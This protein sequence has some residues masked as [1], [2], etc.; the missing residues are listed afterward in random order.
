MVP[1]R[2]KT[3]KKGP[4]VMSKSE[5]TQSR[6]RKEWKDQS[7]LASFGFRRT[8]PRPH[9]AVTPDCANDSQSEP[10]TAHAASVILIM[11]EKEGSS[12]LNSISS[13]PK[14]HLLASGN[15]C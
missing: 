15:R 4:D 5:R 13:E 8:A 6:Y 9:R 2:P 11:S 7:T 3:Y 10:L 12:N 14:D 1:A